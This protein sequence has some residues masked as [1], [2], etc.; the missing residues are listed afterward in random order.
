MKL[1]EIIKILKNKAILDGADAEFIN[2]NTDT[3]TLMVGD[4]YLALKGDN[5]D[6]HDF[7]LKAKELGASGALVDHKI[8]VDL[9]QIIV[10][11]VRLALGEIGVWQ[12]NK[13]NIPLIAITG[14]CGKTT[15]KEM[16]AA[17]LRQCGNTLASIKSF[18]ND[19]GV[20]L[21]LWQL[22]NNYQYAVLEVGANHFGEISYLTNLIKPD[23]AV[24]INALSGHLEGFGDVAGVSRAKGE[25]LEG[26]K[27]NGIAVLNADDNY[28][29]YWRDLAGKHKVLSFGIE[30]K[31]DVRAESILLDAKGRP[32]FKMIFP[33]G[34]KID[35]NLPLLGKHNV[36]NAL[37]AAAATFSIGVSVAAI[38]NGLESLA[39]VYMRLVSRIGFNGAE[40]IDDCYNAIPQ[41]VI[42]AL[43]LLA[44]YP[45]EKILVFGCMRELGKEAASWHRAVGAKARELG[46]NHLYVVGEFADEVAQAFG[47]NAE[48]FADK[49]QLIL[50]LK[51][52]LDANKVVLIKGSRG[53]HLEE[54]V[55]S[56]VTS[57]RPVLNQVKRQL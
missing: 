3:R 48:V 34:K 55:K 32:S 31:A 8:A 2:L 27:P 49:A 33:N 41:A 45:K 54:V 47:K 26:L 15:T 28:F 13:F 53:A 11:D 42:A 40:I 43:Q 50:A 19:I 1:S 5:F 23:V 30:S 36:V 37:A 17:I 14:T 56:L 12:R 57:Q 16:T 39:H 7:V 25:I 46:I 35:V 22:Q 38:K 6:G 29:A 20:P 4:F 52:N 51:K 10:P 44:Q 21:T 9:P 18:N 24:I